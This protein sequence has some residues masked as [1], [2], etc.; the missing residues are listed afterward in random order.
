MIEKLRRIW[1]AEPTKEEVEKI[2]FDRLDLGASLRRYHRAAQDEFAPIGPV[3]PNRALLD[4]VEDYR[5]YFGLSDAF[6]EQWG[7]KL[8]EDE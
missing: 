7:H 6:L 5:E 8:T 2:L 3:D 1:R 4:R